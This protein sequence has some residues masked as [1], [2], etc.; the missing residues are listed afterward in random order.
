V[1]VQV[2]FLFLTPKAKRV[3][4]LRGQGMSLK[5][6]FAVADREFT[7]DGMSLKPDATSAILGSGVSQMGEVQI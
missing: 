1:R 3:Q 7:R 2:D 4:Q 5:Q 6:A